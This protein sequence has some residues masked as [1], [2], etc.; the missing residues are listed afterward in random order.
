MATII[1]T[2]KDAAGN[3]VVPR[4]QVE[5]ITN[6]SGTLLSS[7]LGK[8][9]QIVPLEHSY[10]DG[11]HELTGAD[12]KTGLVIGLFS[13]AAAFS[14]D[15]TIKVDDNQYAIKGMD[16]SVV[17]GEVWGEGYTVVVILNV[18]MATFCVVGSAS[19]AAIE[20]IV[21]AH[22]ADT[23][24]HADIRNLIGTVQSDLQAASE[25]IP[26]VYSSTSEPT[27]ADGKA[28]DIWVV[29]A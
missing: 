17:S 22:D 19:T 5:A 12:G 6:A 28:G 26:T 7:L 16:G 23:G 2:L 15:Q 4:T 11:V 24:A 10:A 9:D 21:T 13:A 14:A 18:D 29:T 25:T 3:Q 20:E 1:K 27:A 8:S